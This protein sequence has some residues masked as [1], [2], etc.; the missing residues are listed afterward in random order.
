MSRLWDIV[1]HRLVQYKKDPVTGGITNLTAAGKVALY[2]G[3]A[4]PCNN[5]LMAS[6]PTVTVNTTSQIA[7]GVSVST[8]K[9][10]QF[11]IPP[12]G[13]FWPASIIDN[14]AEGTTGG[15]LRAAVDYW[16]ATD[17]PTFEIIHRPDGYNS[18]LRLYV[19]EGDGW[20][21]ASNVVAGNAFDGVTKYVTVATGSRKMRIWE[22]SGLRVPFDSLR[23]G[24]TDSVM[25]PAVPS[26]RAVVTGDSFT[27]GTGASSASLGFPK[28]LCNL[29]GIRKVLISGLGGTGYS[30]TS[31]GTRKR[32]KNRFATDI[33]PFPT[34]IYIHCN[35]VNDTAVSQAQLQADATAAFAL[36]AAANPN[37]VQIVFPGFN[38]RQAMPQSAR[39]AIRDAAATVGAVFID[40]WADGEITGT[41]YVNGATG[42]GNGDWVIGGTDGSDTTHPTTT[43]HDYL[44]RSRAYAIQ[45]AMAALRPNVR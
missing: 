3:A 13:R 16:I 26:L 6:P 2:L 25:T 24:P 7:S 42:T 44:A 15:T 17:A 33:A 37:A 29:L 4:S 19:N 1:K 12:A 32:L 23:V 5:V 35:G 38:P 45:S 8:S 34:D 30:G 21:V 18:D 36:S 28:L 27:E 40:T 14:S 11:P 10:D 22:I 39:D 9:I 31:V 41:G 43:G 20:K